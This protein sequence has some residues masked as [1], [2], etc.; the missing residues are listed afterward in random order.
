MNTD[1]VSDLLWGQRTTN[2]ENKYDLHSYINLIKNYEGKEK[3]HPT[4][5]MI[6]NVTLNLWHQQNIL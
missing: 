6:H 3:F 2:L 1:F 5:K 4:S